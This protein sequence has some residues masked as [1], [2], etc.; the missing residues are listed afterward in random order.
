MAYRGRGCDVS[1][2]YHLS[3]SFYSGGSKLEFPEPSIRKLGLISDLNVTS[4]CGLP[5]FAKSVEGL[6][7]YMKDCR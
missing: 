2:F 6:G 1:P 3:P 5:A 7:P 4:W